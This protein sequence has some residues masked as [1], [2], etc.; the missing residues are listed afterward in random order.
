MEHHIKSIRP[1]IGAKDFETS[2]AFYRDL[3]FEE[4]VLST[5]LSVFKPVQLLF[6]CRKHM[7]KI[8]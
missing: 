4:F 5:N 8:G 1:F 6:I 2:R 7:L 3:S